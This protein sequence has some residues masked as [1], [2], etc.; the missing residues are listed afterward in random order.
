[1]GQRLR[2]MIGGIP[3]RLALAGGWIDQP[4]VSRLAEGGGSMVTARV[5]PTFPFMERAG[6]ATGTR[7]VMRQRWGDV[8]P[9]RPTGELV[10]E[11]YDAENDGKAAPSGSQDMIGLLTAGV[12]RLDYDVGHGGGVFPKHVEVCRDAEVIDW[13][14]RHLHLLP[15]GPRPAGYDPLVEDRVTAELATRLGRS[16]RDCF[17]AI[18][19]RDLAA[20]GRSMNGC[21]A[22][23]AEMLP[24][25]M[26]HPTLTVDLPALLAAYQEDHPG[27][28]FSGCGGGYLI[29]ASETP[30]PGTFGVTLS[31]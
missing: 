15:V 29:V 25:V 19:G 23:W 6:I 9:D 11:I 21:S 20:L 5:E 27:A 14:E 26:R 18:V 8:V 22:C 31:R 10:R 30:P 1:M 7:K 2:E 13:L 4:F 17:E 12:C 28:M 24:G 3:Y 16:G